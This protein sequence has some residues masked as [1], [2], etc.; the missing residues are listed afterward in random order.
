MIPINLIR[1]FLGMIMKYKNQINIATYFQ[2]NYITK[3]ILVGA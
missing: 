2:T 3:T 1:G